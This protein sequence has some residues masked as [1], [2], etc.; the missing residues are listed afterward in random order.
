MTDTA[1]GSTPGDLGPEAIQ[2]PHCDGATMPN[3]LPDGSYVCSCTAE[4]A[5][6]LETAHGTPWDGEPITMPA[7]MDDPSF[8]PSGARGHATPPGAMAETG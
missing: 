5:L 6:P 7:L 2:C 1:P 8:A 3:L 4:R